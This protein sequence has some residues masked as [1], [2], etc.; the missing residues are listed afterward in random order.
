MLIIPIILAVLCYQESLR[1]V[2][3]N[4]EYEN[5]IMLEQAADVMDERVEELN[6]IGIQLI[7][8]TQVKNLRYVTKPFQAPNLAKLISARETMSKYGTFNDFLF[9]YILYFN[10]GSFALN[11]QAVYA[12]PDFYKLYMHEPEQ[13]YEEWLQKRQNALPSYGTC[14]AVT[15]DYARSN[16]DQPERLQLVEF[17][18]SFFP[19]EG[20]DGYAALY[21]KQDLMLDLI[22]GASLSGSSVLIENAKNGLIGARLAEGVNIDLLREALNDMDEEYTSEQRLIDGSE[23]QTV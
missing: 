23:K 6:N 17:V 19:Y 22:P 5:R 13:T 18:Y 4:I 14:T 8:S 1:I 16:I 11:D 20:V 2:Q 7:S 3:Q 15:V 12:Y 10:K 21:V 9:D